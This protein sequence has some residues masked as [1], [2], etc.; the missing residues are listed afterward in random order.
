MLKML[1]SLI[2]KSDSGRSNIGGLALDIREAI[3]GKEMDPQRLIELQAE[4]NKVEAQNRNIFVSGWRPMVGWICAAAFG[5]H[6]IVMPLLIAYTDIEPVEFDT[7]S[8]FTVLMGMLGL[9]GLRTFEKL[10]DKTK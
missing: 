3:K 6:Y 9:G 8:L 1:L 4:I 7:N 2:G 10:K 5:F